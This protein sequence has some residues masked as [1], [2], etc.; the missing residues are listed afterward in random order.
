VTILDGII[1]TIIG[2][3]LIVALEYFINHGKDGQL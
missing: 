1:L 3:A 2:V